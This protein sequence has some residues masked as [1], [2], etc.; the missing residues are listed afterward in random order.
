MSV[1]ENSIVEPQPRSANRPGVGADAHGLD[2]ASSRGRWLALLAA[3]LGWM[4]DGFEMGLHPLVAAPALRELLGPELRAGMPSGADAAAV[5][6]RL[7]SLVGWWNAI[8]NALFLF[9]AATGGVFFGW[10]GDRIGRT[11][12]LTLTILTY[13]LLTGLGGF[14]TTVWHLA[15]TRFLAAIGMGGEWSLGVA[16]VMELWPGSARPYLAGA[17]GVA[18]NGGYLLVALTSLALGA[19]TGQS[20]SQWRW[21]MFIGVAP[22]LLTFLIRLAVPESPRWEHATVHA[23]PPPR[24]GELLARGVRGRCLL[25]TLLVGI[26]LLGTW[27]AVQWIPFWAVSLAGPGVPG[28][29]EYAQICSACGACLGTLLAALLAGRFGRKPTYLVLCVLSL[30]TTG[31]LFRTPQVFGPAFLGGV[32]TVGL[33]TAAFYGWAPLYLPELFPTRV[34]ATAQGVAYN[35]GRIFAG[36]GTLALTGALLDRFRSDLPASLAVTSLIYLAGIALI[37]FAPETRGRRLPD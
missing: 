6:A 34:R 33:T 11:R 28:A 25:A 1:E 21:L 3:A 10:L 22:A 36:L 4:F 23:P 20:P 24:P 14:S 13:T 32:F 29:K 37:G 18:G 19:S 15:T 35:F 8:L 26:A 2:P 27:G 12:T 17:I 30:L 16:L 9:G 5:A 31:W 7:A